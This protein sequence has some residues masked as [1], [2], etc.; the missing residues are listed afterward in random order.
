MMREQ[1]PGM[2]PAV[3]KGAHV[4]PGLKSQKQ[5]QYLEAEGK[6]WN[7]NRSNNF[8]VIAPA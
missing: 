1:V 7:K 4:F 5:D 8:L 3:R 6:I 2:W